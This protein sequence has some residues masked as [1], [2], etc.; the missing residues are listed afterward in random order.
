MRSKMHFP[1]LKQGTIVIVHNL[2]NRFFL[3]DY[4]LQDVPLMVSAADIAVRPYLR[5]AMR[6]IGIKAHLGTSGPILV[7][8][9]GYSLM[10]AAHA[11]FKIYDLI[12]LYRY[13]EADAY[14]VL[15]LPPS[16]GDSRKMRSRKWRATLSNLDL[17]LKELPEARL[18]P[19]IH[20]HSLDE[21]ASACRDIQRRTDC[22]PIVALGGIVPFLRGQMSGQHFSY[23]RANGFGGKGETF[24]ADAI[25]ICGNEFP[26]SHIHVFGAGSTTTSVAL[27]SLGA[28]SVDSL[29][30]RRA[31][32]FGTIFLAGLAERTVS[33]KERLRESRPRLTTKDRELLKQC[34]CPVCLKH[35]KIEDKMDAL[36]A[37][38]VA[39]AVHNVWTLRAEERAFR[40]AKAKGCVAAFAVSRISLRHRFAEIITERFQDRQPIESVHQSRR[41]AAS[42]RRHKGRR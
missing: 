34:R 13:L 25:S 18:M 33:S 39:R 1:L 15:D 31:A 28:H 4:G 10:T 42:S 36:G 9:G 8:S 38:Y 6:T 26:S 19:V 21:I 29:A 5:R 22:P 14:A 3:S 23:K 20:G 12:E 16:P 2:R 7:D 32:G 40:R 35:P 30:W 24:I 17:M 41:A 37:S 27:L 11:P